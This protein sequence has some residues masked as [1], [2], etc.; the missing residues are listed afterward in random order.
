VHSAKVLIMISLRL[1]PKLIA[2]LFVLVGAYY[3]IPKSLGAHPIWS[4]KIALIGAP[5]G[6]FLSMILRGMSWPR[7]IG[8][9]LVALILSAIAAHQG[10]LN[11][12]A[13]YA[14]NQLAGQFWYFGWIAVAASITALVTT[15][16]SPRLLRR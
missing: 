12:V 6:I 13:S 3:G 10:R 15:L 7:R 8:F 4:F 5:V 1:A 2:L 9:C 11:F 14:E 16:L